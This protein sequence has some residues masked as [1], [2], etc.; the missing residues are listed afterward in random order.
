MTLC[1]ILPERR[2]WIN[3]IYIHIYIHVS[4]LCSPKFRYASTLM[5]INA[6]TKHLYVYI[7]IYIY[8]YVCVWGGENKIWDLEK[9][10]QSEK[11]FDRFGFWKNRIV[12]WLKRIWGNEVLIKMLFWGWS[13]D[14]NVILGMKCRSKCYFGDEVLIEMLFW[15]W[16][17]DRNVILGMKCWSKCYFG[18]EV[19]IEMLSWR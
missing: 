11:K 7:F 13:V 5:H 4:Y 8:I 6:Y 12:N 14:R 17:V 18:Y 10:Y 19:Y 1:H 9:F 15:G 2:G 3:M 16:S